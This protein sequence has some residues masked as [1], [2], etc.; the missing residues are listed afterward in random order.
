MGS[1]KSDVQTPCCRRTTNSLVR[2]V[3]VEERLDAPDHF[4]GA[5]PQNTGGTEPNRTATRMGL[6][7]AAIDR[8]KSSPLPR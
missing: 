4:L 1:L 5:P 8:I 2:F 6:K 3:E 7:A